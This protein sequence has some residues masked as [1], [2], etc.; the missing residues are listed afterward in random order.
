MK[1]SFANDIKP[2][3]R[4]T[5]I[6]CMQAY[7]VLLDNFGYMSDATNNHENA[8]TVQDYLTGKRTPRMP[9][10]GPYWTRQQVDLYA[11]WIADGYQP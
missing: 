5:D 1:T 10:G 3:F 6:K 4:P 9:K 2:L 8:A 7:G 11:K